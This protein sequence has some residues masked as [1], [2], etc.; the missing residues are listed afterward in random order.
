ML[1]VSNTDT[2]AITVEMTIKGIALDEVTARKLAGDLGNDFLRWR[3]GLNPESEINVTLM[4][5]AAPVMESDDPTNE[6]PIEPET[7]A[8]PTK[9]TAAEIAAMSPADY[10]AAKAAGRI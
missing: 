4:V 10:R 6:T 2:K 1:V 8:S 9:A 3:L 7:P 5:D